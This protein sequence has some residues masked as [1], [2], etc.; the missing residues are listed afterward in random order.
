MIMDSQQIRLNAAIPGSFPLLPDFRT[1]LTGA[2]LLKNYYSLYLHYFYGN[3]LPASFPRH[4][5]AQF[6]NNSFKMQLKNAIS[7]QTSTVYGLINIQNQYLTDYYSLYTHYSNGVNLPEN[8]PAAI[9][10]KFPNKTYEKQLKKAILTL[11]DEVNQ[12]KEAM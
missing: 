9:L 4:L 1:V 8:F 3:P 10:R 12:E 11:Q 2:K 6:P 5:V 7:L